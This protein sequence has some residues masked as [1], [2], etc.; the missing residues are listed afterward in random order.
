M[1]GGRDGPDS[2][3]GLPWT[4]HSVERLPVPFRA[5]RHSLTVPGRVR[6]HENPTR[7]YR[8]PHGDALVTDIGSLGVSPVRP[9][10]CIGTPLLSSL[11]P[12]RTSPGVS[13]DRSPRRSG[14]GDGPDP[15]G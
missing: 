8:D 7:P 11:S 9:T 3:L 13:C 1:V 14:S 4:R 12:T 15:E 5:L 2:R 6:L 10:R